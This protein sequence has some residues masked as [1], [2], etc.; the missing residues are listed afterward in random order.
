MCTITYIARMSTLIIFKKKITSVFVLSFLHYLPYAVIA[1]MTFPA[2]FSSTDSLIS[3]I[4]GMLIAII[5]S[6]FNKS[7]LTVTVL[8]IIS[9]YLVHVV[10][11]FI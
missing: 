3:A 1:A 9:A 8:G 2:I 5:L 6:W 4:W 7:L 11:N 10:L